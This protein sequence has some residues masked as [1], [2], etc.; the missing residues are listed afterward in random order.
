MSFLLTAFLPAPTENLH[1]TKTSLSLSIFLTSEWPPLV[2]K[3]G[4][5]RVRLKDIVSMKT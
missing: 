3:S 1:T 4:G 2:T 5:V